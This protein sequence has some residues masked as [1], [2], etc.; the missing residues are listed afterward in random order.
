MAL[1]APTTSTW[2]PNQLSTKGVAFRRI[3]FSADE[4]ALAA[5][6]IQGIGLDASGNFTLDTTTSLDLNITG[7]L[8]I[9]ASGTISLDGVGN[10]N[11]TTSTGN[12]VLATTTSGVVDI[13]AAGNFTMDAGGTMSLD[14]VGASNVT[15]TSGNLTLSTITSGNVILTSADGEI[16]CN[17]LIRPTA[18]GGDASTAA[19]LIGVG[20]SGTPATTAVANKSFFE[21]RCQSTATSGTSYGLYLGMQAHGAGAEHIAIRG[22]VPLTAAAG[23]AHGGHF[24]LE[25]DGTGK[26]TGLGTGCRMNWVMPDAATPAGGTYYGAMAEIYSNGANSSA[27]AV[28]QHAILAVQSAGHATG[29]A[30][31]KNAIAFAGTD[32]SGEMIYAHTITTPGAA[33]GSVKCLFNGVVGHLYWWT[34]EGTT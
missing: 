22:R 32:G 23:N 12:L 8:T 9:D 6:T 26:V 3:Y 34:A 14:A 19:L 1:P 31:V 18:A 24:T 2:R 7:N 11:I 4:A 13:N 15:A 25:D 29:M 10:S 20:T 5:G 33:Q 17:D 21:H 28:T 27:A 16:T 30:T